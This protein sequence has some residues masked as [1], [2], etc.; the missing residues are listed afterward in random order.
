MWHEQPGAQD[1]TLTALKC[2]IAGCKQN[3]L[4]VDRKAITM[5]ARVGG[6]GIFEGTTLG[7]KPLVSHVCP[8]HRGQ[9]ARR[10]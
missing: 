9:R 3:L 2:D 1:T 4:G 8:T 6:W 7:G 5:R 10:S